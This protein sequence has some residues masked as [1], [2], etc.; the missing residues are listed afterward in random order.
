[1]LMKTRVTTSR[2]GRITIPAAIRRRWRT[3]TIALEDRGDRLVLTPAVD[4]PIAAAEGAL[5]DEMSDRF[6][7]ARL[8]REARATERV[9]EGRR[10]NR[11]RSHDEHDQRVKALREFIGESETEHGVI[12]E[13]EMR[14]ARLYFSTRTTHVRPRSPALK[15]RSTRGPL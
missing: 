6:G 5:A 1:M 15:S 2:G 3:S 13:Q 7:I 11:R 9:A 10:T 12:T 8:R 14:D 4:D